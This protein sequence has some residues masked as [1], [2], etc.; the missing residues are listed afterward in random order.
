MRLAIILLM[1]TAAWGQQ[2]DKHPAR[3][4]PRN[5][6]DAPPITQTRDI[7]AGDPAVVNIVTKPGCEATVEKD[8]IT[9]A[10]TKAEDRQ[11][12]TTS[13]IRGKT[14]PGLV[15]GQPEAP[16]YV[17]ITESDGKMHRV[18]P[19]YQHLYRWV[20]C[21]EG[22][23]C[24]ESSHVYV[25]D[26]ESCVDDI[27]TVTEREWQELVARLKALEHPIVVDGTSAG[28]C[29]TPPDDPTKPCDKNQP[30]RKGKK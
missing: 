27:H 1:S 30:S 7:P 21:K 24:V 28:D 25:I 5:F 26:H 18:C 23:T 14:C 8:T 17:E 2:A 12:D 29:K 13:C 10:P 6:L 19:K 22:E 15:I 20:T 9:V 3:K 11:T 4:D 16:G